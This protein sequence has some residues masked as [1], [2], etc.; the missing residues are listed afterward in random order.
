MKRRIAM[1]MTIVNKIYASVAVVTAA[2]IGLA[3]FAD[4]NISHM[5]K[6]IDEI[7]RY[8]EVQAQIAPRIIDHLKWAENLAVG[9]LLM[10][11]EFKGQTDPTK[12]KFGEWYYGY[13]PP[14]AVRDAY[15]AIDEPHKRLHATAGKIMAAVSAG[16]HDLA[17]KIY[18]D[19]TTPALED[20]QAALI[21]MRLE[22]K[23]KVVGKMS[24]ELAADQRDMG[25]D[26]MYVFAVIILF[27]GASALVF[28]ARPIRQGLAAIGAWVEEMAGG[29]LAAKADIKSDDEL[30]DM[31]AKLNRMREK[32]KT[33]IVQTKE[34]SGQVSDAADQMADASQNFA[35]RITEQAASIEETSATMEEMS[36]S[37]RQ[38]AE[39]V[40]ESGRLAQSTR[41][42]AESGSE[43]MVST[44]AALD[45][46]N[47]SSG[48]IANISNVI[49][50][51][52]FQTNLLALNAAVEAARAGEHGK[53]FAVVASEIRNLAQ[54]TSQSAR[55]ITGL[56]EDSVDKTGRGVQLAQEL[57]RK[58]EEIGTGVRKVTDLMDEISAA[59]GEQSAG[60]SQVNVA[61]SQIDQVT[62][63]NAS[64]V[65]EMASASDEMAAEAK[66]LMNIVSFFISDDTEKAGME[67]HHLAQPARLPARRD[68]R[69]RRIARRAQS[70]CGRTSFDRGARQ[71]GDAPTY[72]GKNMP[73]DFAQYD[74][75]D[76]Q[77]Y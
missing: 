46:M 67:D 66:N 65:E 19:E 59:A 36:A 68:R 57:N 32:L 38:T 23:D 25:R 8:R 48:K 41:A 55:E 28:L 22:F 7:D 9:T 45:D 53:G 27:L 33:V 49:E 61:M 40:R 44:I 34:S 4:A 56:I 35:Q 17:K 63:Q 16:N 5:G 52:A 20:T 12:C 71:A 11:H 70:G 3:L 13:T 2:L 18:Q 60:I 42:L 37:I 58:L 21:R 77:K 26:L 51:V 73:A 69:P 14:D 29:N 64:L 72:G 6:R 75:E 1:R 10:G 74:D 54:R 76:F 47:R 31:A 24:A 39:N 30:G 50:D 62:Q 15:R 43:V